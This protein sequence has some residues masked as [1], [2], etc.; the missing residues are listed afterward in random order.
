[1]VVK[2]DEIQ[3]S[4]MKIFFDAGFLNT[5]GKDFYIE[6]LNKK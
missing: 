2:L 6:L 4:D 5:K 3:L 1:M